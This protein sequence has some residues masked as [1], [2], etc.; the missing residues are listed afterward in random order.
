M[1]I[2]IFKLALIT[3]AG[4]GFAYG[5]AMALIFVR[6][7]LDRKLGLEKDRLSYKEF[8]ILFVI[9]FILLIPISFALVYYGK[10][11]AYLAIALM[12]L[13]IIPVV[14]KLKLWE[15]HRSYIGWTIFALLFMIVFMQFQDVKAETPTPQNEPTQV[16]TRNPSSDSPSNV[17][18]LFALLGLGA[19][20]FGVSGVAVARRSH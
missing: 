13:L 4:I 12:A 5:T 20:A 2:H 16:S 8:S 11:T 17:E 9:F 18:W 19:L 6:N 1:I 14:L 15:N 7:W 3:V 10:S